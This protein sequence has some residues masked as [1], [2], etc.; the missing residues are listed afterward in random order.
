M[1]ANLLLDLDYADKLQ[2]SPQL[3]EAI[4]KWRDWHAAHEGGDVRTFQVKL[5]EA[6]TELPAL[7]PTAVKALKS[8]PPDI[9]FVSIWPRAPV[10]TDEG[11]AI[12]RVLTAACC[13]HVGVKIM[14]D[15]TG[16]ISREFEVCHFPAGE[17]VESVIRVI[18]PA[19]GK[20]TVT[21]IASEVDSTVGHF[22]GDTTYETK[23]WRFEVEG[24]PPP[25]RRLA[26][27]LAGRQFPPLK[28]IDKFRIQPG[29]SIVKIPGLKYEFTCQFRG[30]RLGI[31]GREPTGEEE[32]IVF[33]DRTEQ[34][35][36]DGWTIANCSMEFPGD[37]EW[38]VIFW[39]SG[40]QAAVQKVFVEP[41]GGMQLSIVEH[42]ALRAPLPSGI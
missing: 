41:D 26:R 21:A 28:C 33:A 40:E 9:Q 39:V 25:K 5:H 13:P 29:E 23:R 15:V 10:F 12:M 16:D 2:D 38:R 34:P 42:E 20:Y 4:S 31:N 6:R 17:K 35:G 8:L 1:R 36:N 27:I 24:A 30:D 32:K 7:N 18:F 14:N 19:N 22:L 3:A 11:A 37:G